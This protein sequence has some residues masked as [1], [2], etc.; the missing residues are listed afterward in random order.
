MGGSDPQG[1]QDPQGVLVPPLGDQ[2]PIKGEGNEV[3]LVPLGRTNGESIQALFSFARIMTNHVNRVVDSRV[4][5]IEST[6][7]SRL[8]DFVVMNPP[9]FL[10]TMVGDDS[11]VFMM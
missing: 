9:I 2:V 3:L 5:A 11:H 6:M 10:V 1:V 4:N 7:T 8:R